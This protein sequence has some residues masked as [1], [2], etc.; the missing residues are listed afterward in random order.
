MSDI[1]LTIDGA[2]LGEQAILTLCRENGIFNLQ[3]ETYKK[4]EDGRLEASYGAIDLN[5]QELPHILHMLQAMANLI[6]HHIAYAED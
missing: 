4:Q 1:T 3:L 5:P 6:Q 2:Q